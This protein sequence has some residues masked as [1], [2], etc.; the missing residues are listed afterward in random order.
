MDF[1]SAISEESNMSQ[2]ASFLIA[3]LV[4]ITLAVSAFGALAE[5]PWKVLPPMPELPPATVSGPVH[6]NDIDMW[7]AEFGPWDGKPVIMVHGGLSNSNYFGNV[8]PLP[9]ERRLPRH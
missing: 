8:I 7:R 5:Q 9:G 2:R 4:G 3:A 1:P 6:V